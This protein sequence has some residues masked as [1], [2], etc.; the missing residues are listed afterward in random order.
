MVASV[1]VAAAG[2]DDEV[3]DEPGGE[4]QD[5]E[6]PDDEQRPAWMLSELGRAFGAI[7]HVRLRCGG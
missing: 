3:Q 2:E 1:Q 6:D 4:E 7:F 5:A